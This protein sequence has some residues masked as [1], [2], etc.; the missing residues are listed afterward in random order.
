M[1]K[2]NIITIFSALACLAL[3]TIAQAAPTPETPDPGSTCAFCTADGANALLNAS[4]GGG[5]ANSAFGWFSLFADT[6]ASFNTAVGAGR[7][8][9]TTKATIRLLERQRCYSTPPAVTTPR[10]ERPRLKTTC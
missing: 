1:K 8:C 5:T 2:R 9:S 10:L 4:A 7:S 3:L 6:D